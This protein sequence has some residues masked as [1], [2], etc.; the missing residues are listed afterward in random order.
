MPSAV[1]VHPALPLR[2]EAQ[3]SFEDMTP[4]RT[5]ATDGESSGSSMMSKSVTFISSSAPATSSNSSTS[6]AHTIVESA[7]ATPTSGTLVNPLT[8]SSLLLDVESLVAQKQHQLTYFQ[9]QQR[10]QQH[11]QRQLLYHHQQLQRRQ[12]Q[13]RQHQQ[14]QQKQVY[15]AEKRHQINIQQYAL[16]RQTCGGQEEIG[17]STGPDDRNKH[18]VDSGSGVVSCNNEAAMHSVNK[19]PSMTL[20]K[21]STRDADLVDDVWRLVFYILA[22]D[23]KDLGR[24]MQVSRRFYGL[25][26][27]DAVLWKLTYNLT[28]SGSIFAGQK[29]LLPLSAPSWIREEQ[30]QQLLHF[31][32]N[33][34]EG[35]LR[36]QQQQRQDKIGLESPSGHVDMNEDRPDT[37]S[38]NTTEPRLTRRHSVGVV[39]GEPSRQSAGGL[40]CTAISNR[41][42]VPF[43]EP[44]WGSMT[45]TPGLQMPSPLVLPHHRRIVQ[46]ITCSIMANIRNTCSDNHNGNLNNGNSGDDISA[47][48]IQPIMD[49]SINPQSLAI[50]GMN[51]SHRLGDRST[52]KTPASTPS[53]LS[54]PTFQSTLHSS[55]SQVVS[56]STTP[57]SVIQHH[58][59]TTTLMHH[60]PAVYWKYQVVEWLEQ[61]KLRCLRL[62]LFWGFN[63]VASRAHGRKARR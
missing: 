18:A 27:N 57:L 6:S 63:A 52:T 8:T 49:R 7:T 40:G 35:L 30:N 14:H 1:T 41:D 34:P 50:S 9:K 17:V 5:S 53:S 13:R 36:E 24:T 21:R 38:V 20:T 47:I 11:Q 45:M 55:V 37:L 22:R 44:R 62:G 19:T 2:T 25:I 10:M 39:S 51:S 58:I 23:C 12:L 4:A 16:L 28:V 48:H 15:Q 46:N 29:P 59:P 61:E 26:A 60:P 31:N 3:S 33:E 32:P 42:A 56:N 54:V 43:T